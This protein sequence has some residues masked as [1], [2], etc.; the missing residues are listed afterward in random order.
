[1]SISRYRIRQQSTV[2][3]LVACAVLLA[4]CAST[5]PTAQ[6]AATHTVVH[7]TPEA[8]R[9]LDANG[10]DAVMAEHVKAEFLH[11][12]RGYRQYA[13]GRD[14]LKPLS[15]TGSDWYAESL[16]MTPVDALDTLLVMG[17]TD[18]A[19]AARELIAT[20]LSF[21]KDLDVK[22]F[23]IVIRLLGGLLSGYQ[24]TGDARL[25][26]L[27][28]D[29]G[30][31]LL[32]AFDSP[33]GLPYVTVNLRTGKASGTESNPAESGT[34]LLEYGTLARLTGKQVYWDKA[35][36]ALEATYAMRSPIGLVGERFD[37][38][39]GRWTQTRTH[40]GAR[41]DSYYEYLWKCWQLFAE[42]RCKTMWDTHI[43][44]I[45]THVADE[46]DGALWYGHVDMATGARIAPR[47]GAL[48]AFYSGLLAVSGDLDR[49]ARLQHSAFSMW[50][51]HGIEP[52]V[53]DYRAHAV[54]SPG[55]PL[56]PEIIESAWYLYRLT[57][58]SAWR[59]MGRT[60][61]DDFIRHT[62]TP[63]GFAG[64]ADVVT[65]EKKDEMESF[66]L[67]ET[68]KYFY[69]LYADP[70][71]LDPATTVLTTEAHPLRAVA[72]SR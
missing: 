33:T 18:E 60:M 22:H 61:F 54:V 72:P 3:A 53:W 15:N 62:R 47:F 52:E 11:G 64:L 35:W 27:A 70:A 46:V 36:R 14:A 51:A 7:V 29:L 19:D 32:P 48:D 42:P 2:L 55:Y 44:A 40:V 45:N 5:A 28:D 8:Q 13:W 41:I 25:L 6:T 43:A 59:D 66:V 69:L 50:Q 12:W 9:R 67:A 17:L 26:A 39:T 65:K 34:L 56:R 21:D 63:S 49:A 31:R 24:M 37:V 4:G 10:A 23:E 38:T 16:L 68:F 20:Q 1:M 71:T 30:T 58:D 57:G